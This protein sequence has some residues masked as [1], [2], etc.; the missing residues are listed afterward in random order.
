MKSDR[1]GSVAWNQYAKK[2]DI[3]VKSEKLFQVVLLLCN[4]VISF[5]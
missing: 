2:G 5:T 4:F 1:E 3:G